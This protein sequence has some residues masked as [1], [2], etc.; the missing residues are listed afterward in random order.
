MKAFPSYLFADKR[1]VNLAVTIII[2]SVLRI[3]IVFLI[4]YIFITVKDKVITMI[5]ERKEK[6]VNV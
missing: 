5:R 6:K 2:H 1:Y 3:A 4:C